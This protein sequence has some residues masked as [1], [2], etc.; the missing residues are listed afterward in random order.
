MAVSQA[1]M[2]NIYALERKTSARVRFS[3][4]PR[5]IKDGGTTILPTPNAQSRDWQIM[6]DEREHYHVLSFEPARCLLDGSYI[7]PPEGQ[8]YLEIG[9]W[10]EAMSN[11]AGVYETPL[12]IEHTFPETFTFNSLGITFETRP[13]ADF[14]ADF[15]VEFFDASNNLLHLEE[16]RNNN[17]F[18][19]N[20]PRAGINVLRFRITFYRTSMPH[21]FLKII[22]LDFGTIIN[23]TDDEL[24]SVITIRKADHNGKRYIYPE[25]AVRV[26]N[27]DNEYH[28][29]DLDSPA[30]YFVRRQRLESEYGLH[31]PDGTIEWVNNGTFFLANWKVSDS[32][33]DLI[34]KGRTFELEML[35]FRRSSFEEMTLREL[36]ALIYP[37]YYVPID[38]P[39][40]TAF[41]GNVNHRRAI[42]ML[43]E[44]SCAI[45]FEDRNNILRF[46][47][48]ALDLVPTALLD[49]D[50]QW[51]IDS[52]GYALMTGEMLTAGGGGVQVVDS[53]NYINSY[54]HP[55][56]RV[57]EFYNTILLTEYD[58]TIEERQISRTTQYMGDIE[59]VFSN[60]IVGTPTFT[61]SSPMHNL[62]N[63]QW[64]TMYMTAQMIGL[65][66]APDIPVE[67]T[68]HGQSVNLVG[69]ETRFPAPWHSG[70][71]E[72]VPYHV[73]LPFFIKTAPHYRELRDWFL[74][75]KFKILR[76]HIRIRNHW[77][78]NPDRELAD[79]MEA[80]F[81]RNGDSQ[82]M[83]VT[84][85]ESHYRDGA[86]E[87]HIDVIGENP[88]LLQIEGDGQ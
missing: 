22:E 83:I 41:F 81:N 48:V 78:D 51:L 86:L 75:R 10:T 30:A 53:L 79:L 62:I 17:L 46:S 39:P 60:P 68:I 19:Y 7:L 76:K 64:H 42:T 4:Y 59:V 13:D 45:A 18:T 85:L 15:D 12:V 1:F 82:P 35:I 21:R 61:V 43:I 63:V 73:N 65:P 88:K 20:T 69:N 56:V 49:S 3:L 54:D 23:Y 28:V 47:E 29:L 27:I 14:V 31:L 58:M 6:N 52:D 72:D 77:Q 50:E 32:F 8:Q 25:L 36:V 16:V 87:G 74:E 24:S 84:T 40:I 66:S 5:G 80:E 34:A 71:E 11:A 38:S 2:D 9:Y 67:L 33:L 26:H 70:Y 44:L 57:E 55:Q 37:D